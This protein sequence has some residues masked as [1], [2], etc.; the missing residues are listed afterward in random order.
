MPTS[1][2]LWFPN[3]ALT[4]EKF[5]FLD[6][7]FTNVKSSGL[8]AEASGNK[9][10]MAKSFNEVKCYIINREKIKLI[11]ESNYITQGV[12]YHLYTSNVHILLH[13]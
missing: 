1:R 13:N 3:N 12:L 4:V 2:Y 9:T 7:Y 8:Q 5:S 11:S 6:L 10:K